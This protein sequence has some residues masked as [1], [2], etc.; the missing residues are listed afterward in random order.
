MQFVVHQSKQTTAGI[1]RIF[2]YEVPAA[3]NSVGQIDQADASRILGKINDNYGYVGLEYASYL[4]S[5][6]ATISKDIENFYK[7]IGNKLNT[8]QEERYWRVMVCCLLKGAEYANK[9]N[10][11]NIDLTT[12]QAFLF[13]VVGDLRLER[14]SSSVDLEKA[15]NVSEI[16]T[17]FVGEQ[18]ARHMVTTDTSIVRLASPH[19]APS[20]SRTTYR[21]WRT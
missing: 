9:M 10:F 7:S 16:V 20:K 18:S 2:E 1:N 6:H 19:R 17:R 15:I 21:G 14:G 13:G 5:N 3:V 4:G 8:T 11:T 12:L